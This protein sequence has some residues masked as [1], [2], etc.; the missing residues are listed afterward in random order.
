[1]SRMNGQLT[2]QS[3]SNNTALGDDASSASTLRCFTATERVTIVEVGAVAIDSAHVP[4]SSFAFRA[5][6]RTGGNSANDI[7]VDLFTAP[8]AAEG[9]VAG[10]SSVL[11]FDNAHAIASGIVTNT[12]ALLTAGKCLRAY[13]EVSLDKGDQIC[14]DITTGGGALSVVV[15]YAKAYPNGAGIVESNDVDS[16]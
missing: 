9:G 13:C 4:N 16:N 12:A 5:I 10:D 1:M 14:L 6:K 8:F 11:N 3:P 7:V 15:F 2:F